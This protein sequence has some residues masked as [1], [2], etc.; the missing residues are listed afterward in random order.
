MRVFLHHYGKNGYSIQFL[1]VPYL[2]LQENP[3]QI[4]LEL[5]KERLKRS[6]TEKE[7]LHLVRDKI[8]ATI[9]KLNEAANSLV[10]QL[11]RNEEA[12]VIAKGDVFPGVYVEVC[13]CSYIVTRKMKGVR[14]RLDKTKGKVAVE[15]LG[16]AKFH[17]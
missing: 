14:F 3:L 7:Q 11:D 4:Y 17:G 16:R 9:H 8:K 1:D 15:P 10:Y 5:V 6:S 13:H 12:E 2:E